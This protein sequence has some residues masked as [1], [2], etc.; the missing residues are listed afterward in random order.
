MKHCSIL[1]NITDKESDMLSHDYSG[2]NGYK[3]NLNDNSSNNDSICDLNN[4]NIV[5]LGNYLKIQ[6][7]Y[8]VSMN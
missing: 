4:E 8:D 2:K 6:Y 1:H 5:I 3:I 7:F